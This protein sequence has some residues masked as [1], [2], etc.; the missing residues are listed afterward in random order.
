RRAH[1][2]IKPVAPERGEL[3]LQIEDQRGLVEA[4]R[5]A[6]R[7]RMK[8]NDEIAMPPK[9]EGKPGAGRM[10]ADLRIDRRAAGGGAVGQRLKPRPQL[11]LEG[12]LVAGS[13]SAEQ[14]RKRV[15]PP[16]A[17]APESF[18]RLL[19]GVE[20]FLVIAPARKR[21]GFDDREPPGGERRFGSH[22]GKHLVGDALGKSRAGGRLGGREVGHDG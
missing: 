20:N 2:V 17:T 14:D 19:K 3:R 13:G 21:P 1:L 7:C 16:A 18:R 12:S 9:A 5:R 8:P 15:E 22:A 11:R 6:A 10:L 4:A